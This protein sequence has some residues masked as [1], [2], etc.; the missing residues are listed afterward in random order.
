VITREDKDDPRVAPTRTRWWT[1]AGAA[2]STRWPATAR[3]CSIRKQLMAL[4]A[5]ARRGRGA[6]LTRRSP[7]IRGQYAHARATHA[8]VHHPRRRRGGAQRPEGR[9]DRCARRRPTH[10]IVFRRVD[11]A[12][13]GGDPGQRRRR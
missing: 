4:L 12:D 1:R 5:A 10:G 11:L 2:W 7:G 8:Q 6:P 13:A 9:A 3:A